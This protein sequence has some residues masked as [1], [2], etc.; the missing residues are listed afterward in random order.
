MM[1]RK[2]IREKKIEKKMR[3]CM[4]TACEARHMHLLCPELPR[5]SRLLMSTVWHVS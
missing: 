2:K 3:K 1:S 5:R 4:L